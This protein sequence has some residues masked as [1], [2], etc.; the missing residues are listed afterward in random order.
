MENND[1]KN[2]NKLLR[3]C[4]GDLIILVLIKDRGLTNKPMKLLSK[5]FIKICAKKRRFYLYSLNT[6]N[7]D[8]HLTL[9]LT[10]ESCILNCEELEP[11]LVSI[12]EFLKV[13]NSIYVLKLVIGLAV[14]CK[15]SKNFQPLLKN[16]LL[17]V[18]L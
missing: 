9:L 2:I 10:I 4:T 11:F 6:D 12:E 1:F 8:Y 16:S 15:I 5:C 13:I 3:R 7:G 14:K 18:Y 17:T